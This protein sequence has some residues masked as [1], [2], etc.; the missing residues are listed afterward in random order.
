MSKFIHLHCP[1]T[2]HTVPSFT[3]S[4]YHSPE[5]IHQAIRLALKIPHA[6]LYTTS[7]K[8]ITKLDSIQD[9]QRVL[10]AAS[11]DEVMLP[12]SPVASEFYYGQEEGDVDPD[13]DLAAW[14]HL[15]EQ[16]RCRHIESLN[17]LKPETRNK[18]R[19]TRHWDDVSA[20]LAPERL[21][22]SKDAEAL[23]EQ[24]W[25]T[26]LDH[27]LPSSM[28][29]FKLKPSP[30]ANEFWDPRAVGAI[31]VLAGMM[32]G[33]ARL[34]VGYLGE[35]VRMRVG[36]GED[37]SGVVQYGDVV[38]AV[39]M[40]SEKAGV[41]PARMAKGKGRKGREKEKKRAARAERKKGKG[42]D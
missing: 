24:R 32:L 18:L 29:P 27:F 1:T 25:A 10:V 26:T 42:G 38:G 5:Q 12:D 16:G 14:A 6:S 13:L 39:E 28:K 9:S 2:N 36:E 34:A 7:A 31:A 37:R 11:E 15:D 19:Y 4:P 23:I 22:R 40:I 17:E 35:A 41:V 3:I 20:N 33:Q 30:A 21:P 8:P